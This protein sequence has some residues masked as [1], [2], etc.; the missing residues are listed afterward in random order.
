MSAAGPYHGAKVLPELLQLTPGPGVSPLIVRHSEIPAVDDLL[1]RPVS[2][3]SGLFHHCLYPFFISNLF[4]GGLLVLR[5]GGVLEEFVCRNHIHVRVRLFVRRPVVRGRLEFVREVGTQREDSAPV[6]RRKRREVAFADPAGK[7]RCGSAAS[8]TEEADDLRARELAHVALVR[9][10]RP[11]ADKN[12]PVA[13]SQLI[14]IAPVR[15]LHT[16]AQKIG[17]VRAVQLR[18]VALVRELR[19]TAQYSRQVPSV[20]L[21]PVASVRELRPVEQKIVPVCAVQL[22]PVAPVRKARLVPKQI[23]PI[24][25]V[26][27][28]CKCVF[29]RE[30]R[31]AEQKLR[32]V[33]AVQFGPVALVRE[34]RLMLEQVRP[35][36]SAQMR[37]VS[38]RVVAKAGRQRRRFHRLFGIGIDNAVLPM[39]AVVFVMEIDTATFPSEGAELVEEHDHALVE[40]G[41]PWRLG[42]GVVHFRERGRGLFPGFR[43]DLLDEIEVFAGILSADDLV[44]LH[45]ALVVA[46][47]QFGISPVRLA[48]SGEVRLHPG[49]HLL[50]RAFRGSFYADVLA[51]AA[52]PLIYLHLFLHLFFSF[53]IRNGSESV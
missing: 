6:R 2:K 35:V 41:G 52:R 48:E 20:Q 38:R 39:P 14:P 21:R 44:L 5:R 28:R 9:E 34:A 43:A 12:V 16:F 32:P 7:T 27:C 1:Q 22:R 13:R 29:V 19:M 45:T 25:S 30:L 18:P 37:P 24:T 50:F 53:H 3:L 15:E 10:L 51:A 46:I 11:L 17:P 47:P 33:A 49:K 26:K 4:Q 31:L 40:R 42:Q 36:R 23:C 8:F